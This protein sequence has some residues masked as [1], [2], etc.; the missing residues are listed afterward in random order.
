MGLWNTDTSSMS[1]AYADELM[2]GTDVS[3]HEDGGYAAQ[4]AMRGRI[5]VHIH[6]WLLII[7]ALAALWFIGGVLFKGVNI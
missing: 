7:G 6:A 1:E 4:G 5:P 3:M 2:E